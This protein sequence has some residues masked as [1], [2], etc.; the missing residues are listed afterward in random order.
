M[1]NRPTVQVE[2]THWGSDPKV[3]N[4]V[5]AVASGSAVYLGGTDLPPAILHWV[6]IPLNLASILANA[7]LLIWFNQRSTTPPGT[8]QP[9]FNGTSP[10]QKESA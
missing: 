7:I 9:P 6:L 1:S 5:A 4:A 10:N 8:V 2:A 3:W